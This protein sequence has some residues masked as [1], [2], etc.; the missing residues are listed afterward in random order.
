MC[1]RIAG[2]RIGD[3]C[4]LSDTGMNK[5]DVAVGDC[6]NEKSRVWEG[7]CPVRCHV[8]LPQG[9]VVSTG[10]QPSEGEVAS[11]TC[12]GMMGPEGRLE[13]FKTCQ[14]ERA[15]GKGHSFQLYREPGF[16]LQML[17]RATTTNTE[18]ISS[19]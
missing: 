4:R 18:Y 19:Y 6:E 15:E 17:K 7:R 1:L 14:E 12:V 16:C 11:R 5:A 10:H 3:K 13:G 9:S 2:N 8:R